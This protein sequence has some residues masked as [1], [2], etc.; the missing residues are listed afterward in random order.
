MRCS[1]CGRGRRAPGRGRRSCGGAGRRAPG[2]RGR[3]VVGTTPCP[4]GARSRLFPPRFGTARLPPLAGSLPPYWDCWG[5]QDRKFA[6]ARRASE[7]EGSPEHRSAGRLG[8]PTLPGEPPAATEL[9]GPRPGP[10]PL[11]PPAA[12]RRRRQPGRAA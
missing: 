12:G 4:R 2:R 1:G 6:A 7:A 3:G 9:A 11:H 10:S 8:P 5:A